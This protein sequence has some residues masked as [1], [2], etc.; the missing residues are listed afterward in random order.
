MALPSE[1]FLASE[2]LL[3]P[4]SS[5]TPIA[6]QSFVTQ[7]ALEDTSIESGVRLFVD[8]HSEQQSRRLAFAGLGYA[9]FFG[10][11]CFVSGVIIA[12][13]RSDIDHGAFPSGMLEH[14]SAHDILPGAIAIYFKH[15]IVPEILRLVLTQLNTFATEAIGYVHCAT[16]KSILATAKLSPNPNKPELWMIQEVGQSTLQFNTNLRL[17]T[18]PRSVEIPFLHSNNTFFNFIMAFLLILSYAAVSLS[19]VDLSAPA[20]DFSDGGYY[21]SGTAIFGAPMIVL[22]VCILSKSLIAIAGMRNTRIFSW[23]SSPLDSTAAIMAAGI[24]KR[25]EGRCMYTV[26]SHCAGGNS[27]ILATPPHNVHTGSLPRKPST[28]QPSAWRSHRSTKRI[29]VTLWMLVAVCGGWGGIIE[30][31]NNGPPGIGSWSLLPNEQ[32][33]SCTIVPLEGSTIPNGSWLLCFG[34]LVVI[35]GALTMALHCCELIVNI[36]RDE[37][38]WRKA[39]TKEGTRPMSALR[40]FFSFWPGLLLQ[41]AKSGLRKRFQTIRSTLMSAPIAHEVY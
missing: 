31:V 2:W 12:A 40:S 19:F 14:T 36:L 5:I 29:I 37:N 25:V 15:R 33:K 21:W 6:P 10:L 16:Q 4:D 26:S 9:L 32:S 3:E 8:Q 30:T 28:V 11:C 39:T 27:G 34:T 38:T 17:F 7:K 23:S 18:A 41:A 24:V 35:Q 1:N 13:Q 22:G 20:T